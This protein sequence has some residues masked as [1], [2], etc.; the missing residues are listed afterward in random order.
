MKKLLFGLLSL[1][2]LATAC[3]KDKDAPAITKENIA[4]TYKLISIKAS[5]NGSGELDADDREDCEKDDLYK[6]NAD[7]SFNYVDAGTACDPAG[8]FNTT[9][10]L[11]GNEISSEDFADLN[12]TITSFD[13]TNLVIT[14]TYQEGDMTATIKSTFQ[15]Q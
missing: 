8:D 5:L 3:K 12:G 13:G 9:Y 2:L 14:I 10:A 4:G 11:N 15:K 7:N 6:I 1:S